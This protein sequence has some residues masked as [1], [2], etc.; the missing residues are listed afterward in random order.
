LN[1]GKSREFLQRKLS[2][3]TR[4]A[5]WIVDSSGPNIPLPDIDLESGYS[6]SSDSDPD[7]DMRE[8]LRKDAMTVS[9]FSPGSL[10]QEPETLGSRSQ[11]GSQS[12]KIAKPR[13]ARIKSVGRAP[14]RPTPL[15]VNQRHT[16]QS[17]SIETVLVGMA[18]PQEVSPLQRMPTSAHQDIF[19]FF[20]SL[21]SPL[22]AR[23]FPRDY[24]GLGIIQ[25]SASLGSESSSYGRRVLR[26]SD[27]LGMQDYDT[28][29]H[30]K[31][32]FISR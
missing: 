29:T 8:K 28:A 17:V 3:R 31:R 27:V 4:T 26:D 14:R 24:D 21:S 15:P 2:A 32:H 9:W 5:A 30:E 18:V 10:T 23:S 16:P 19:P 25:V 7:E 12:G 6:S 22:P 13:L 20:P 1:T 11:S